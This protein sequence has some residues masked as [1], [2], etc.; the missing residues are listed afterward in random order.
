M[1]SKSLFKKIAVIVSNVVMYAFILLCMAAVML[2]ITS[3]KDVDGASYILGY[4]MRYVTSSSMEKSIHTDVSDYK[5]KDLPLKTLIVIEAVPE[6]K[7]NANKWYAKLK[8]GDVLTFRYRTGASEDGKQETITHRLIEDPVPNSRGGYDLVLQGD[9]RGNDEDPISLGTQ[10]IDTSD[11]E[12]GGFNY[13][14]GKVVADSRLFG[15][16]VYAI[17]QPLG[18]VLIIIVPC[19]IIIIMEIIR[20][21][22]VLG[23]EKT[24]K[25]QEEKK[26]QDS[27]IEELKKQLAALQQGL[28]SA[29]PPPAEAAAPA[30]AEEAPQTE[31]A[32]VQDGQGE[33]ANGSSNTTDI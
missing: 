10:K 15:L 5:I 9:N 27:E 14:I 23:E 22:R 19:V 31:T 29:T 21:M 8:K 7:E 20:I 4:Q 17:K 3:K 25:A 30:Q 2:S 33:T 6:G 24:Q 18:I 32:P 13:V 16:F 12:R 28:V 11:Y 1:H 26:K